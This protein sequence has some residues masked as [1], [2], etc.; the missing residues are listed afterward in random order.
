MQLRI[1]LSSSPS[2]L[3]RLIAGNEEG[4]DLNCPL[5]YLQYSQ[6]VY[7]RKYY[8][9][10]VTFTWEYPINMMHSISIYAISYTLIA[11]CQTSETGLLIGALSGI[12]L[13]VT[14][15]RRCL[16]VRL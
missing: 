1:D 6:I 15:G 3:N 11:R 7:T 9:L 5:I 12:E 8:E 13:P 4:K 14:I 16:Y 10:F 2:L